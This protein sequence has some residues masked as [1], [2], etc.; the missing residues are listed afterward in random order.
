[1]KCALMQNVVLFLGVMAQI[2]K[3]VSFEDKL[4]GFNGMDWRSLQPGVSIERVEH[5][6]TYYKSFMPKGLA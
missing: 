5:I 2:I 1:M 4:S 3:G 6:R